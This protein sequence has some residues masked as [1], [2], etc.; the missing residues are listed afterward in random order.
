[1]AR[2]GAG[3][4]SAPAGTLATTQTAIE[5]ARYNAFVNDL[6]TDANAA[7]P[8][9]A[10]GTG[11]TTAE[12]ALSNLGLTVTAAE[13]NTLDGITA[14][15]TE[16]N[17]VGGATSN[18]QT[19]LNAKSPLLSPTFTGAPTAPTASVGT[20][21]TQIATTAFVNAEIAG[22]VGAANS[23]LVKTAL[24]AGGSAPI[25][26][27]R[28]WVTFTGASGA[29]LGASNVASITRFGAGNY[30]VNFASAA[31]SGNYVPVISSDGGTVFYAYGARLVSSCP[32]NIRGNLGVLV[33]PS[34][35]S[36]AFFW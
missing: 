14:N 2:N 31:P 26:A 15:V 18:I 24:N 22:D 7:R 4:Y 16:I 5:S 29:I 17:Y 28:A 36:V 32:I 23:A 27:C 34:T 33:D 21:T 13:L 6:V 30:T 3:V 10:G 8:I 11:A 20:N 25:Y 19:Q 9:V 1:M 35:V 12:G